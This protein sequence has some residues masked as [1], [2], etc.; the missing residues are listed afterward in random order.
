[1]ALRV[2]LLPLCALIVTACHPA[3]MLH[4]SDMPQRCQAPNPA[5]RMA[6]AR[7][8]LVLRPYKPRDVYDVDGQGKVL[9]FFPGVVAPDALAVVS[10]PQPLLFEG[11]DEGFMQMAGRSFLYDNALVALWLL[12]EGD[13]GKARQV[14][15]AVTALQKSD[16]SWGFSFS[17]NRIDGYY[18]ASYVR[19]GTVAWV[20]YAYAHYRTLTGD[21]RFDDTIAR[22]IRWLLTQHEVRTGLFYAGSGRWRSPRQYEP[23][24]AAQFFATEHQ[25]D[26][27]F[28]LKAVSK[29]LPEL[30]EQHG[31]PQIAER[32]GHAMLTHLWLAEDQRFAQGKLE[33]QVD[34][35]SALD[36]A[37]T[38]AALWLIARGDRQRAVQALDWVQRVHSLE[39]GGWQGL[40]PYR[41]VD[42]TTWFVEGSVAAPLAHW[43]LGQREQAQAPWDELLKLACAGGV[44]L[45]YSPEW[46]QDFPLSPATAPTVWFLIAGSEI[47]ENRPAWLWT[48]Q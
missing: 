22:G 16:G 28:A 13:P 20:L 39:I 27:Y 6:A 21:G 11:A 38:W 14:L 7:A 41:D 19:T 37:G 9:R 31:L 36:A 45:V 46:W 48:E 34:T 33:N 42:P 40:R 10:F 47:V 3:A 30:A 15:S 1:M 43:R 29:A 18:N 12:H 4:K 2:L 5:E 32:L 44:P 23:Y 8:S 17:T 24:W 35:E 26:I 25:I